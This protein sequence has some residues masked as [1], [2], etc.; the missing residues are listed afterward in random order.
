MNHEHTAQCEHI[1]HAIEERYEKL[2][3]GYAGVFSDVSSLKRTIYGDE[4][5]DEMGMKEKVDEMHIIITQLKG[6]K[7]I[8]GS[9]V[10]VSATLAAL[11]VIIW[12]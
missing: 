6:L 4:K 9:V 11:K 7:W 8:L 2:A 12:K 1:E 3:M 10:L 5:S